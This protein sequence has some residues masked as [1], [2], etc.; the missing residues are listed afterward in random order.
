MELKTTTMA[1]KLRDRDE[2]VRERL[3]V[4][5][6]LIFD[7]NEESPNKPPSPPPK[8]NHMVYEETIGDLVRQK[9]QKWNF[10]FENGT[11]VPGPYEW[12]EVNKYNL[13]NVTNRFLAVRVDRPSNDEESLTR[14]NVLYEA[15]ENLQRKSSYG[16]SRNQKFKQTILK[17]QFFLITFIDIFC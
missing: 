13:A 8:H 1:C 3:K 5:R 11:P 16:K 9:S 10:D 14:K 2:F 12:V 15:N 7:D 17:G 6:K 4:R